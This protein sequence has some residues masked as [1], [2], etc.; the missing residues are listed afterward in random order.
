MSTLIK[1]QDFKGKIYEDIFLAPYT[2]FKIGGKVDYLVIPN[3]WEDVFLILEESKKKNIPVKIIGQGSNI[4]VP[5]EGL[6]AVV[7]KI[8]RNLG[9]IERIDNNY[10]EIESGCLLSE[11]L[12]FLIRNDL[13]GLEFLAGIPGNVGGSVYGN[14]GAWGKAIGDFVEEVKII[15]NNLNEKVL[16]KERIK[17][18]YRKS[19]IPENCI[20]KSVRL[21][22]YRQKGEITQNNIINFLK[23]RSRK[24]P[25]FPSAGSI[26]KNPPLQS[27]GYLLE[28]AG[29]KGRRIGNIMV[30]NEHANI[31]VNLGG[32]K[33]KEVKNLIEIMKKRVESLFGVCL[34][35]EI[36]IW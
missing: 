2:S 16:N 8:N 12:S 13:G 14:A 1:R 34:E 35:L 9:K 11:L 23:E 3:N 27:A 28:K 10:I 20:I 29:M 25:K 7:I 18:E 17:F 26:F 22:V 4:L 21:K 36:K 30:S 15:D 5:D 24:F 31:I 33:A 19:N 6:K 32:G